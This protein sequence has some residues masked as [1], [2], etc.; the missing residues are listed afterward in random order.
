M[1]I[2]DF[3]ERQRLLEKLTEIS[4]FDDD[5]EILVVIKDKRMPLAEKIR[6]PS[7]P[8]LWN[9]IRRISNNKFD[10]DNVEIYYKKRPK[11]RM[12]FPLR[13]EKN[14]KIKPKGT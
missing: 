5:P 12:V 8:V 11:I 13:R 1:F 9:A 7:L 14:E 10:E 3:L 2:E 6:C 4:D